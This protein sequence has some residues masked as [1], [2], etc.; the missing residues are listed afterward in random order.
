[1]SNPHTKTLQLGKVDAFGSGRRINAVEIEIRIE[2]DGRRLAITGGIWNGRHTD[3][4]SCG[5][6]LDQIGRL[7]PG[8]AKVQRI[9]KVWERWHLND[10]RAGDPAQENWLRENGRGRDYTET[11]DRLAEAGLLVHDGYRYGS[12]WLSEEL[13]AE[14][15]AEVQSW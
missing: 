9:V 1:M 4:A 14:I 15:V 13:P 5:Q 10:L 11:V 8:S 3:Y 6:N 12:A 2:N 7:F